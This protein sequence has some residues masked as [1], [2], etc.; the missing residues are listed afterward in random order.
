MV[1]TD[2]HTHIWQSPEQLGPAAARWMRCSRGDPWDQ[3][4]VS[5]EAYD[6][7][8]DTVGCAVILGFHSEH[9]GACVSH[10]QV[11][12]Y[13]Q[14]RPEKYLGFAGV[15]PLA[16]DA[17]EQLRRATDAGL[18][19]VVVSPAGQACHP[20]HTRALNLY[21]WCE[22]RGLPVLFHPHTHLGAPAVLEF[23]RPHLLDEV[24]RTFPGLRMVV[25][26]VGHPW[27]GEA[28]ALLGKHEHVYADLT[29]LIHRPWDLY[30]TLISANE[31]G[32]MDR[33][34]FGSDYP[35]VSPQDAIV[36]IYSINTLTHGTHLPCIPRE[37]LRGIIEREALKCLGLER[38]AGEPRANHDPAGS[39]EGLDRCI[40]I[41]A[42]SPDN[43]RR[44]RTSS[45]TQGHDAPA[46]EHAQR[47]ADPP[48]EGTRDRFA[49]ASGAG[50]DPS[51]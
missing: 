30:Q 48:H 5:V 24:A 13:V 37:R 28:L 3:S 39:P 47:G 17:V 11:A 12:Q 8:M 1:I 7:A 36:T 16:G 20:T 6:R 46:T 15:D 27:A 29:D 9:L 14:R 4:K 44:D 10:E 22:Q 2:I 41:T 26:Q 32:A 34:L 40:T 19:G 25:G 42:V 45:P 51:R 38:P 49:A 18:V 31:H 21:A 50:E 33:L 35:F 43:L 23:A